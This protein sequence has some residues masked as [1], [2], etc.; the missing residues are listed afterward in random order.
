MVGAYGEVVVENEEVKVLW[1][2]NFQSD[3]VIEARKSDII[4]IDKKE[5]KGIIIDIALPADV[6]VKGKSGTKPGL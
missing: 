2:I 4:V 1:D 6:R 3:I 5:R